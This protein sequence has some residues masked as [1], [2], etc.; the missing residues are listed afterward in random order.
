MEKCY[1]NGITKQFCPQATELELLYA[2]LIVRSERTT[3]EVS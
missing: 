2:Q 1:L 3:G